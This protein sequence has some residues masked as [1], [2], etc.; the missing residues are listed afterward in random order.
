MWDE[1][2]R[3]FK[4]TNGGATWSGS[5]TGLTNTSVNI[6]AIDPQ[7]P[8]TLY[9]GTNGGG[10]FKSTD[11]GAHWSDM[12]TGLFNPKSGLWRSTRRRRLPSMQARTAA[13]CFLYSR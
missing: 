5:S 6:L 3:V 11:G 7:T 4:S 13:V 1:W 10:V 2:W 12:N 9:V 8:T